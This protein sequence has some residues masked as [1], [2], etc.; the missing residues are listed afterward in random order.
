M[1]LIIRVNNIPTGSINVNNTPFTTII[2]TGSVNIQVV[3]G[4]G[5]LVGEL[6][7]SQWL[8]PDVH[9]VDMISLGSN[10]SYAT[11]A[12]FRDSS[13]LTVA[14]QSIVN[15]TIDSGSLYI[16]SS[17]GLS[18]FISQSI[19]DGDAIQFNYTPTDTG[20]VFKVLL[21]LE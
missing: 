4:T 20:S 1:S 5:S 16:S 2:P 9:Y 6:S 7:G 10:T 21:N 14:T 8:V 19:S 3:N 12:S 11:T 13:T 17:N 15:G 18:E